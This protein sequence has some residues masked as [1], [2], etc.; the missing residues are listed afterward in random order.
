M[1]EV[2]FP[3]LVSLQAPHYIITENTAKIKLHVTWLNTLIGCR[4]L[5]G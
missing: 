2:H 5:A 1:V 3:A 4:Q